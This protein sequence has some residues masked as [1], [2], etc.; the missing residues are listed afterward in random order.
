VDLNQGLKS[1]DLSLQFKVRVI[2]FWTASDTISD[3]VF[4]LF[5]MIHKFISLDAQS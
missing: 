5:L 3:R 2:W 4:W 1:Y